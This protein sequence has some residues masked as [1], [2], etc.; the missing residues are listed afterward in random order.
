MLSWVLGFGKV[1]G[2][3]TP[4]LICGTL[5]YL[6]CSIILPYSFFIF[7]IIIDWSRMSKKEGFG[8]SHYAEV[9]K[10]GL[11]WLTLTTRFSAHFCTEVAKYL[12]GMSKLPK[13]LKKIEK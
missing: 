11:K 7:I 6:K 3:S 4:P 8:S 5:K 2:L 10:L 1:K 12:T 9:E 13:N